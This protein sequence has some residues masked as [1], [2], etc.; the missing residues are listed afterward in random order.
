MACDQHN[1]HVLS[2]DN[3]GHP[4]RTYHRIILHWGNIPR[5]NWESNQ[6]S[7]DQ[8][9]TTLPQSHADVDNLTHNILV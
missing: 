6:R 2:E 1:A 4:A 3:T 5:Q 8:K 9:A 7:L